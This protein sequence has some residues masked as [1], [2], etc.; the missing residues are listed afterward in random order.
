MDPESI[1]EGD[2]VSFEDVIAEQFQD[3][4]YIEI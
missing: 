2:R 3:T 4:N 1:D